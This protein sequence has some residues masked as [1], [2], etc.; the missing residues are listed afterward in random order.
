[1]NN[2]HDLIAEASG[3][4][5]AEIADG[6]RKVSQAFEDAA[7]RYELAGRTDPV[8]AERIGRASWQYLD[9]IEAVLLKRDDAARWSE[10]LCAVLE[11]KDYA[12]EWIDLATADQAKR[13]TRLIAI[14]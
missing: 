6:T 14:R 12:R 13:I 7:Q 5:A 3:V 1:M 4:L 10:M 8:D 9:R 11:M 2:P